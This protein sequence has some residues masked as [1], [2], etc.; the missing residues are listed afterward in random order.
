MSTT[1]SRTL[2]AAAWAA[3]GALAAGAAEATTVSNTYNLAA[4]G[5][6]PGAPAD[7]VV[8]SITLTF[9]PAVPVSGAAIDSIVLDIAGHAYPRAEVAFGFNGLDLFVKAGG[10]RPGTGA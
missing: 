1:L 5:F 9:D 6:G 2:V 10:P 8:G 4:A 7:P 3:A